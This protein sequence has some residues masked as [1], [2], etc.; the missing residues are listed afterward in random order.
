[1]ALFAVKNTPDQ[2]LAVIANTPAEG[3]TMQ[4]EDDLKKQNH[5][6]RRVPSENFN[7]ESLSNDECGQKEG[8]YYITEPTSF[9]S[10]NY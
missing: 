8:S 7:S 1:M 6:A 5:S 3:V 10:I 4:S 2:G 9:L